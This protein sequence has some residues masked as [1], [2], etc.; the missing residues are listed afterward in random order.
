MRT[1]AAATLALPGATG[2]GLGPEPDAALGRALRRRSFEE[3]LTPTVAPVGAGGVLVRSQ[4][5]PPR[6]APGRRRR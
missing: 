1:M 2:R 3:E 5:Q 6:P 4:Q